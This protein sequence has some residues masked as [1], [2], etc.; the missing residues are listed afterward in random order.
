MV[1]NA[2]YLGHYVVGLQIGFARVVDKPTLIPIVC[3]INA[4]GKEVIVFILLHLN[5][6][7][8]SIIKFIHIE[9]VAHSKLVILFAPIISISGSENLPNVFNNE[10]TCRDSLSSKQPPHDCLFLL[11][12]DHSALSDPFD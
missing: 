9:K 3:G 1:H 12:V 7:L 6:I 5:V 4:K 10:C 2:I 11:T 8:I